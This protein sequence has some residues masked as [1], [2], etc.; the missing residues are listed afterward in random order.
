[1]FE[2]MEFEWRPKGGRPMG[3]GRTRPAR[4]FRPAPVYGGGWPYRAPV[5]EPLPLLE[6]PAGDEPG[7]DEG[8]GDGE[9]P[10][11]IAAA[12]GRMPPA[13]QPAYAL[14]GPLDRAPGDPRTHGPGLTAPIVSPW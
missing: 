1:M 4:K 9:V 5:F 8:D 7:P 11:T 10:P 13:L 3:R 14:I 12:V 6:P 2:T